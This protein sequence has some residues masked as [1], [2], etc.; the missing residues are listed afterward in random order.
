MGSHQTSS[1]SFSAA[2]IGGGI[3]GLTLAIA[4]Q[5]R[6]IKVQIYE[7]ATKFRQVSYGLAMSPTANR[8]I[9]LIDPHL[10]EIYKTLVTTHRGGPGDED[11]EATWFRVVWGSGKNEGHAVF[12]FK[13]STGMTSLR[14]AEFLNL[15]TSFIPRESIHFNKRLL[16]LR[17]IDSGL[18]VV[19]EDG[20][21]G[22]FEVV[23]GCD[24][25]HS[26]VRKSMLPNETT[27]PQYSG[28]FAY[29]AVLD[30]ETVIEAVG[31]ERARIATKYIS[32]GACGVSYPVD[33]SRKVNVG[34]YRT[35][36]SQT[37]GQDR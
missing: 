10:G 25:V 18:R 22:T 3:S 17:E 28:M 32:K 34:L 23:V 37:W 6:H 7:A 9:P 4:L 16:Y 5:Q 1:K 29:R 33:R 13:S 36:P 24:G 11:L 35:S 12:D 21:S 8:V 31:E 30:M 15:L 19:F 2:I 26:N 27:E 14:R 20:T